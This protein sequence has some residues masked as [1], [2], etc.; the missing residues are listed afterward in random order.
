MLV[1]GPWLLTGV[2]ESGINYGIALMPGGD[3]GAYNPL[4]DHLAAVIPQAAHLDIRTV[5]LRAAAINIPVRICQLNSH[6]FVFV[7][8][9]GRCL[10]IQT[11]LFKQILV[12]EEIIGTC[13]HRN[14]VVRTVKFTQLQYFRVEIFL[15]Q[16]RSLEDPVDIHNSSYIQMCGLRNYGGEMITS[17]GDGT[18][19]YNLADNEGYAKYL[20]LMAGLISNGQGTMEGGGDDLF[21]TGVNCTAESP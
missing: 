17:N 5:V 10:R 19:T 3:A 15:L 9:C 2:K 16:V 7:P 11:C 13:L 6:L 1:S 14:K 20:G 18:F 8:G 4:M 12:P 21:R